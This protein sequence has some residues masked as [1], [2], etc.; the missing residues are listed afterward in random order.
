MIT[1]SGQT[2]WASHNLDLYN[3]RFSELDQIDAE[4]VGRLQ[5]RWSYVA[6]PGLNVGQ[7]T[8]LVVDGVMYFHAGATVLAVNAVTG[9]EIWKL[10]IDG[11]SGGPVR[12]PLYVNGT[13]Y[14]YHGDKLAA[15]DAETGE[16]VETF[17][18]GGVLPVFGLA[19]AHKYPDSY[20]PGFDPSRSLPHQQSP[21]YHDTRWNRLGDLR[22]HNPRTRG[23]RRRRPAPSSG[24]ST[25]SR[26]ARRTRL[27][28]AESTGEAAVGRV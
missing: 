19:L 18:E 13:L 17:G 12:G 9:A 24:C 1:G 21:A 11:V 27:G 16:L 22:G 23:G 26:N 5:R 15:V 7:T 3:Q 20:P 2:N 10:E 14:S 4:T 25:P 6:A 8:P 28:V